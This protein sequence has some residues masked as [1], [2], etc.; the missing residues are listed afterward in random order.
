MSLM[1]WDELLECYER[2][3]AYRDE[4]ALDSGSGSSS[5]DSLFGEHERDEDE[6]MDLD[7]IIPQVT[8]IWA[9]RFGGTD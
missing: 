6:G 5:D 8:R 2:S 4:P 9:V 1:Q 3:P 7:S